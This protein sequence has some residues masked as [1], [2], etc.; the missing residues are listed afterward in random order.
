MK[1]KNSS[2]GLLAT[3]AC[4]FS[5]LGLTS[6]IAAESADLNGSFEN[7]SYSSATSF[8]GGLAQVL[9]SNGPSTTAEFP[10]LPVSPWLGGWI[11]SQLN[12]V[13]WVENA[14]SAYDGS[15]F[16]VLDG[17]DSCLNLLYGYGTISYNSYTPII[18]GLTYEISFWAASA[19]DYSGGGTPASQQLRIEEGG[20][21]TTIN[22]PVNAAWSDTTTSS[23]P[24]QQYTYQF[25][26]TSAFGSFAISTAAGS[27]SAIA[28]DGVQFA[29]A[30]AAV[31]EA[32][33]TLLSAL[34]GMLMLNRRR[35]A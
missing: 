17:Q 5:G 23:I 24:W 27:A 19:R 10:N 11:P 29:E 15:K 13:K 33:S 32:G 18:P 30:P 31:P 6:S 7:G 21:T 26:A 22:L 4:G 20:A 35:K 8:A 25:T 34:A 1:L 12:S 14:A 16:L 9:A 2:L 3:L 28:I